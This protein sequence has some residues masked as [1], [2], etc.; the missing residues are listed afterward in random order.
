MKRKCFQIIIKKELKSMDQ[1]KIKILKLNNCQLIKRANKKKI[2]SRNKIMLLNK[3]KYKYKIKSFMIKII[4]K[5]I[6]FLLY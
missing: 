1:L 6:N 4:Y 2:K 3:N 5:R